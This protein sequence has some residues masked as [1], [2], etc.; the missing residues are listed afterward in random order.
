MEVLIKKGNK[1]IKIT[2]KDIDLHYTS[3][4]ENLILLIKELV[5]EL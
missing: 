4:V 2:T 3:N 1:L 5:K